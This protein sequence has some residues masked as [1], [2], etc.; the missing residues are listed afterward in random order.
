MRVKMK[1]STILLLTLV[2][3]IVLVALI[4]RLAEVYLPDRSARVFVKEG[5]QYQWGASPVNEAG[6][7]LWAQDDFQEG[8]RPMEF[9]GKPPGRDGH[10]TLWLK[11][12]LPEGRYENPALYIKFIRQNFILYH[13]NR[14]IYRHGEL[15]APPAER[16]QPWMPPHLVMLPSDFK[17]GTVTFQISSAYDSIG[18]YSPMEVASLNTLLGNKVN[19]DLF[20]VINGVIML[21]LGCGA[22]ILYLRLRDSEYGY[23]SGYVF[24]VSL[25]NLSSTFVKDF[26]Y[27]A[28][29]FWTAVIVFAAMAL[30]ISWQG[31]LRIFAADR[32]R[33]HVGQIMGATIAVAGS[34][35]LL[36]LYNAT[37]IPLAIGV[38]SLITLAN[39]LLMWWVLL[40][41]IRQNLSAQLF[42]AATTVWMVFFLSD[43][44]VLQ[45]V[46]QVHN[47]HTYYGQFVEAVAFT[48]ILSLR[49]LAV[50]KANQQYVQEVAEK[51]VQLQ[52]MQDTLQQWNTTLEEIVATRT[53]EL[54]VIADTAK[55][56]II[57][58]DPTGR[59]S[60][61]NPGAQE[62]LGYKREEALGL[63]LHRLLTPARYHSD[64]DRA[65]EHF[66]QTGQGNA[67]GKTVELEACHKDGHEIPVELSLSA[68]ELRD[69]WHGVGILRDITDRKRLEAEIRHMANHDALTGLPSRR[70]LDEQFRL[71]LA[72]ARRHH[73]KLAVLFMDLDGFKAINDSFGHEV[74]D[75]MLRHVAAQLRGCI[76]ESDTVGR[77]GGDEFL[78]IAADIHRP[79]DAAQIADKIIAAINRPLILGSQQAVVGVS[80]G[81]ALYP[82]DGQ[83]IVDLIKIADQAMYA[84]KK[85]GKNRYRFAGNEF[86]HQNN[87]PRESR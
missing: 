22:S 78:V 61:W 5:W 32:R 27:P 21:S 77:C 82:D 65:Y 75:T 20:K 45:F 15:P 40:P 85:E 6:Q 35:F 81:I 54:Q 64:H 48:A 3:G 67:V 56:A 31:F 12:S 43:A 14:V 38:S 53:T 39:Y 69:G 37:F 18:I 66:L 47:L 79:D 41:L 11:V 71:A 16:Y 51:N 50:K 73:G 25:L 29:S 33:R 80:I 49:F 4:S 36:F 19:D 34:T 58:M 76:R 30:Q 2:V 44:V 74:G 7:P 52:Q 55:D 9:G 42:A 83:T 63:D 70:L 59:I 10:D 17:G 28:P 84:A 1:K 13:G 24:M 86:L 87:R 68:V 57:M 8:F 62:M 46:P 72:T 60:F 23:F 26:V